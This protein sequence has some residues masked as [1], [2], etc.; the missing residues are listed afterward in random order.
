MN[1]N[2]GLIL[3]WLVRNVQRLSEESLRTKMKEERKEH[4]VLLSILLIM[5]GGERSGGNADGRHSGRRFRL[6]D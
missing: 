5:A 2:L 4:A 6:G 1:S 3:A